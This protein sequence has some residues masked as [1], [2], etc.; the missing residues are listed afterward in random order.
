[1]QGH[2]QGRDYGSKMLA[3]GETIQCEVVGSCYLH[4]EAYRGVHQR[5]WRGVL[6]LNEVRDGT[7]QEMPMTLAYLCRKYEGVELYDYMKGKYP[8]QNWEHL[9]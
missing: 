1:M 4:R 9:S 2:V 8:D 7:W 3:T 6:I 5:H